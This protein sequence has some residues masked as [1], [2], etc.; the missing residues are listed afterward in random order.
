MMMM[1]MMMMVVVVVVAVVVVVVV[2]VVY[3]HPNRGS[4]SSLP[5]AQQ[6]D[7]DQATHVFQ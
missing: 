3:M 7:E 5:D 4:M 1:M 2:V 6:C